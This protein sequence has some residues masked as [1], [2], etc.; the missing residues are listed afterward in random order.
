MKKLSSFFVHVFDSHVAFSIVPCCLCSGGVWTSCMAA[1][2]CKEES[3]KSEHARREKPMELPVPLEAVPRTGTA[4]LTFFVSCGPNS[5]R[6][7]LC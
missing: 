4:L 5:H 7:A 3:L 6:K 2:G 1:L